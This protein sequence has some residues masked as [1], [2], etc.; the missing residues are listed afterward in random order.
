M[1]EESQALVR[2]VPGWAADGI[3]D[4]GMPRFRET[5]RI[6]KSV[7]PYTE[8]EREATPS[9][10]EENPGPYQLFLRE[11]EGREMKPG[12]RGFPLALWPV[13]GPAMFRMLSARNIL[14]VEQLA[15]LVASPDMP[16]EFREVANRAKQMLAMSDNL[17]K[18]EGQLRDMTEQRDVLVEQVKELQASLSAANALVNTLKLKVA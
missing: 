6:I 9:D 16:G 18:F 11:Q 13:I 8:I 4:D 7:P 15:A 10:F 17:G 1:A 14:T 2:F 5:V 3:S 12:E